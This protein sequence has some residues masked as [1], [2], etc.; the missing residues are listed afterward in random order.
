MICEQKNDTHAH[1]YIS[2]TLKLNGI[3]IKYFSMSTENAK[4]SWRYFLFNFV[5]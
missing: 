5:Y 2:K 1:L 4:D 3:E